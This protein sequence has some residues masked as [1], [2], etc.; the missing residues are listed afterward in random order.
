MVRINF[1]KFAPPAQKAIDAIQCIDFYNVV[2]GHQSIHFAIEPHAHVAVDDNRLP[3]AM[4]TQGGLQGVVK[5]LI[6]RVDGVTK[7]DI[8]ENKENEPRKMFDIDS[9]LSESEL[10]EIKNSDWLV[11]TKSNE[12]II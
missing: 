6:V 9:A 12:Y 11:K 3:P 5:F 2:L 7:K 4:F 10:T 8:L 1:Q